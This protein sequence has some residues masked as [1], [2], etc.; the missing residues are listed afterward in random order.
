[1]K[2]II[3]EL[4]KKTIKQLEKE[5]FVVREAIAKL[6]LEIKANP[7]KNTNLL[8]NKRKELAR[9]LTVL[10]EKKDKESSGKVAN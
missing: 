8:T 10:T 3:S 2:K 6:R 9:V 1:M 7:P 4:Q 5:S